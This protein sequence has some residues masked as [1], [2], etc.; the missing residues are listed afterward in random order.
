MKV[1]AITPDMRTKSRA[2]CKKIF[3]KEKRL[4]WKD[5]FTTG[6]ELSSDFVGF[7][8]EM[9]FA[10]L[11]GLP[12]PVFLERGKDDYDWLVNGKRL[13]LKTKSEKT[14]Y[15]LINCY[16]YER[17]KGEIDVFIFGEIYGDWFREIGYIEYDKLL[18]EDK[19]GKLINC[20]KVY[21]PNGSSAYSVKIKNL[22]D[23][24]ELFV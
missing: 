5:K 10:N 3:N 13:D 1:I 17:K 2:L 23:T 9:C 7:L 16:Q 8:G 6:F 12:E 15:F 19:N 11:Y 24:G 18:E 22:K 4:G 14:R 21:F 20:K